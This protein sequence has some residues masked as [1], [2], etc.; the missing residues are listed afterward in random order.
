MTRLHYFLRRFAPVATLG[1]LGLGLNGL[2]QTIY[3][4]TGSATASLDTLA[5][6]G[7]NGS[8]QGTL[9]SDV[10]NFAQ[11]TAVA[12]DLANQKI[13]VGDGNGGNAIYRFNFDGTG[14]TLIASTVAPVTGV[15]LDL[16]NQKI[17]YTT[18]SATAS[19]DTLGVVNFD[20][21]SQSTLA[22]GSGNFLQ[23]T[24]IAFDPVNS[25]LYVG[26]G[27]AG[28]KIL[29]F[30][31]NGGNRT[32]IVTTGAAVAGLALDIPNQ[33]IYYTTGSGTASLDTLGVVNYDGSSQATLASNSGNFAQ[34]TG[35]AFDQ[36][37]QFLYVGDGTGGQAIL[38]FDLSGGSR[39][40]IANTT[41]PVLGLAYPT[42]RPT[43]SSVTATTSNG[44][45]NAGDTISISVNFSSA[46]SIS[47]TPQLTLE[48]GTTDRTVNYASGSG[49]TTL[50]FTYTVQAGDTSSDLDYASTSALALNGGTINES[51]SGTPASLTLPDPG[52]TG[53]LGANKALVIDTTAP[54]VSIG[55]PSSSITRSG[56]VTFTIT[57]SGQNSITLVAHQIQLNTTGNVGVDSIGVSGSGSTRTV[58]LSSLTGNGTVGISLPSGTASDTAGNLAPS[59]GPSTTS[60]VDNTGPTVSISS[61]SVASTQSGPVH[62]TVTYSGATSVSLNVLN[63]QLNT[64]GTAQVNSYSVYGSGSTRTVEFDALTGD[65]TVG[66][67]LPTGTATDSVGNPASGAGPSTTFT[68]SNRPIVTTLAATDLTVT[69]ARLNATVN[70]NSHTTTAAFQSGLDTSYG[71]LSS[72]LLSPDNGITDQSVSASLT[73]LTPNT[74][75]HFRIAATN[76]SGGSV[77]SDLTFTTAANTSAPTNITLSS[78]SVDE[79]E[80]TGTTVGTLSAQDPDAS[81]TATFALVSGTGDTDNASFSVVGTALKTTAAFNY[82]LKSIYS[83]RLSATDAGGASYETDFTIIVN[84]VN[85]APTFSG[86]NLTAT[87]NTAVS[88]LL[89]KLLARTADPEFNTRTV[90]GVDA[91][92]TQGGTVQLIG[93]GIRYTPPTDF[94]GADS[95]QVTFSD[96]V[97][98]TQGTVAVTVSGTSGNGPTL[99]SIVP[100][101]G[102]VQLRFAGIP[103]VSYLIQ[104][105]TTLDSTIPWTTLTTLTA[106]SA[107]FIEHTH[108]SAPSPSYWRAVRAP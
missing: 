29:R 44:S 89:T 66:F 22:S 41:S 49:S 77:G 50:V 15:A 83:I 67:S 18:A 40:V 106:T 35:V 38:R 26:D 3:Y 82:E 78:S 92:S 34:P 70:P 95:F 11:P 47:G 55:S 51:I 91:T 17:Y 53:S 85:E 14:R 20:G 96:G 72:V 12:V 25:N 28:L 84:D 32:Q 75:Y 39:T 100:S 23:P 43:V 62:F 13:Y 102:N 69:G 63:I 60:T 21:S 93:F 64:T 56:P 99:V 45:Y 97:D 10:A 61:P 73:G 101:G 16:T 42:P 94:S 24:A 33:K 87:R 79:N 9:A 52:T 30:D 104:H 76:S 5:K 58:T 71:T 1:L 37:G 57:Y 86:Y 103:G 36:A 7:T 98:S 65:G 19:L 108:L 31:T 107:G 81:D 74:T 54:T 88:V 4:V 48:T 90:T 59:A 46:V 27:A 8:N 6:V 2:G 105:T 68:V 80:P